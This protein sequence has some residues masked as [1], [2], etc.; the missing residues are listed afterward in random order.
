MEDPA[1]GGYFSLR[2]GATFRQLRRVPLGAGGY[3][4]LTRYPARAGFEDLVLLA[5]RSTQPLAWMAVTFPKE[6]YLWFALKNPRQLASTLLWHSNGGRHYAPWNGR[7]RSVLGIEDVTAYFDLGL[8][9]SA[10]PNQLSRRGVPTTLTLTRDRA[11]RIPY[12]MG[13][14]AI[15]R[16]FQTVHG[17]RFGRDNVVFVSPSGVTARQV[18]DM[19]FFLEQ[20]IPSRLRTLRDDRQMRGINHETL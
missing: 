17:V 15:P 9:A 5:T 16:G 13:V 12:V 10:R 20:S 11:L 3:A 6:R 7:H 1:R 2:T 8:A 18:V 14:T 19:S 4:D